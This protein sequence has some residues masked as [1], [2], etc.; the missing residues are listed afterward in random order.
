MW[1][2]KREQERQSLAS[3]ETVFFPL[4]FISWIYKHG[5]AGYD[6]LKPKHPT[7]TMSIDG[8]RGDTA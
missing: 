8:M 7:A 2:E 6:Y 4:D 1:T 3:T 5:A